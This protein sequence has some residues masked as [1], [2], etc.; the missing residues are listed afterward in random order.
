MFDGGACTVSVS[1]NYAQN[2]L[3]SGALA[4]GGTSPTF[5]ATSG[6]NLAVAVD[7]NG[8]VSVS[9]SDDTV[10]VAAGT[11]IIVAP[12]Y[13]VSAL[14]T[15]AIDISV[16]GSPN[17]SAWADVANEDGNFSGLPPYTFATRV[18][19]DGTTGAATPAEV[20]FPAAA[21][22]VSLLYAEEGF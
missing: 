18:T 7:A 19:L 22:A 15:R 10:T 11:K 17:S 16:P 12:Q 1:D 6:G 3:W 20:D 14:A 4:K 8:V 5:A 13:D 9:S 2:L 21:G